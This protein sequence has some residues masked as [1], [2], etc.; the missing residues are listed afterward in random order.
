MD[1][2]FEATLTADTRSRGLNCPGTQ[3]LY[4][5]TY[6]ECARTCAGRRYGAVPAC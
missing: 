5:D 3:W 6:G 4:N 1:L 2:L